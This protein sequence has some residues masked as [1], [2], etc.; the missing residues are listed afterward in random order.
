M[1]RL[2]ATAFLLA[3]TSAQAQPV[4]ADLALSMVRQGVGT[5]VRITLPQP[6]RGPL[7]L[8]PELS[9]T[10][11]TGRF[12]E[13]TPRDHRFFA[14]AALLPE[15]RLFEYAGGLTLAAGPSTRYRWERWVWKTSSRHDGRGHVD[16]I[17]AEFRQDDGVDTGYV[18]E[19]ALG[20]LPVRSRALA[21]FARREHYTRG[22]TLHHVGIRFR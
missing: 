12:G 21:V 19:A 16:L 2:L 3:A 6:L 11:G 10:Y 1:R 22:T 5:N 8:R 4:Q 9:A 17:S 18:A 20:V 13:A 7:A 15:L 14:S